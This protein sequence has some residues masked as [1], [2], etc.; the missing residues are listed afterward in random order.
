MARHPD[1]APMET[2]PLTTAAM[3]G[4]WLAST[5]RRFAAAAPD[6]L[7]RLWADFALLT[8]WHM[9]NAQ[10][11]A[12]AGRRPQTVARVRAGFAAA[13]VANDVTRALAGRIAE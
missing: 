5:P 12:N 3:N 4:D 13:Q 6:A 11:H 10:R 1:F 8:V 7:T 9:H 2:R